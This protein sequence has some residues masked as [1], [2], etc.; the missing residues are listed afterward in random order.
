MTLP[1]NPLTIRYQTPFHSCPKVRSSTRPGRRQLYEYAAACDR[2]VSRRPYTPGIVS[3]QG[4]ERPRR[5]R[6]AR[7]FRTMYRP[8]ISERKRPRSPPRIRTPTA[9]LDGV[10]E[11]FGSRRSTLI[12]SPYDAHV[13]HDVETMGTCG[14]IIWRLWGLMTVL[15]SF[16]R[17]Q[18]ATSPRER[19]RKLVVFSSR[20]SEIVPARQRED[21]SHARPRR[22]KCQSGRAAETSSSSRRSCARDDPKDPRRDG[23]RR[24]S[25]GSSCPPRRASAEHQ[26]L[27]TQTPGDGLTLCLIEAW[28]PVK[29]SPHV[30]RSARAENLRRSAS[31]PRLVLQSKILRRKILAPH[32]SPLSVVHTIGGDVTVRWDRQETRSSPVTPAGVNPFGR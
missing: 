15:D 4:R 20:V 17:G 31:L 28:P 19:P 3:A 13:P 14:P 12:R 26:R 16:S 18:H 32:P 10:Y 30:E 24:W 7:T 1:A 6:S 22:T 5:R 23:N 21:R 9:H 25:S 2:T 8:H 29:T 11:L 27:G